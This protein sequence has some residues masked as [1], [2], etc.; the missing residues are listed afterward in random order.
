MEDTDNASQSNSAGDENLTTAELAERVVTLMREEREMPSMWLLYRCLFEVHEQIS[1]QF[2]EQIDLLKRIRRSAYQTIKKAGKITFNSQLQNFTG[3]LEQCGHVP[4]YPFDMVVE[5]VRQ[6]EPVAARRYLNGLIGLAHDAR[7]S[8]PHRSILALLGRSDRREQPFEW[9]GHELN[10]LGNMLKRVKAI[11]A[12]SLANATD[13]MQPPAAR[14]VTEPEPVYIKPEPVT[15]AEIPKLPWKGSNVALVAIVDALKGAG[16][17]DPD[18]TTDALIIKH[19]Q[20]KSVSTNPENNFRQAR[21]KLHTWGYKRSRNKV[22]RLIVLLKDPNARLPDLEDSDLDD[23]E[24]DESD[25][26]GAD[27]DESDE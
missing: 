25:A 7:F 19:F 22:E 6:M 23:A 11:V 12:E 4:D 20:L 10:D 18:E 16:F 24:I 27:S 8:G 15:A 17:L 21:L 9:T 2:E 1:E 14:A 3:F 5:R 26:E 13:A